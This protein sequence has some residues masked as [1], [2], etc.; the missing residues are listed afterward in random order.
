MRVPIL[1]G[2]TCELIDN[3]SANKNVDITPEGK[4]L[5]KSSVTGVVILREEV[6]VSEEWVEGK[7][8]NQTSYYNPRIRSSSEGP[9]YS[10]T[11]DDSQ[12]LKKNNKFK[13]K[14]M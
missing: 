4:E 8:Y 11:I 5:L 1:A 13:R 2:S 12:W 14:I 7:Y 3:I 9:F 10:I 6:A